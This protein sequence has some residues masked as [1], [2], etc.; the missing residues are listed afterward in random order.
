MYQ[1]PL[2]PQTCPLFLLILMLL[3]SCTNQLMHVKKMLQVRTV[4]LQIFL[5]CLFKRQYLEMRFLLRILPHDF[6]QLNP[7]MQ[8]CPLMLLN[9]HYRTQSTLPFNQDLM[10]LKITKVLKI[11][12]IRNLRSPRFILI[13]WN[14]YMVSAHFRILTR[15]FTEQVCSRILYSFIKIISVHQS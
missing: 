4:F 3:H 6:V 13:F 8:G 7:I 1:G 15:L 12:L 9:Y 11:F 2:T 14:T 10:S 5:S